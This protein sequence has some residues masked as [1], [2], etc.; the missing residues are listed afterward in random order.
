MSRLICALML[1]LLIS[2][3]S[4][5]QQSLVG[6]YK[7]VDYAL[8]IDGIPQK[9][10]AKA[11]HGYYILTPTRAIC[12]YTLGVRKFGTSVEEKAALFNTLAGYSGV[13]RVEGNKII[14]TYDASWVEHLNGTSAVLHWQ[15]SGNRLTV[16]TDPM[17]WP[18]DPTKKLVLRR[19]WEKVE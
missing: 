5:G 4:F 3:P 14:T 12:F 6:T 15:L 18:V 16:T 19:V 7:L 10:P 17:P 8:E 13:Y 9:A 11:P 1:I 2:T